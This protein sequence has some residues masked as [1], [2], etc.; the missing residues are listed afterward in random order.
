MYVPRKCNLDLLDRLSR[1]TNLKEKK[2]ILD[3]ADPHTRWLFENDFDTQNMPDYKRNH[4][5]A[6]SSIPK[7]P[8]TSVMDFLIRKNVPAKRRVPTQS[9][10][11]DPDDPDEIE[12]TATSSVPT[13]VPDKESDRDSDD[14]DDREDSDSDDP[15]DGQKSNYDDSDDREDTLNVTKTVDNFTE[16]EEDI[17]LEEEAESRTVEETQDDRENDNKD[18][19]SNTPLLADYGEGIDDRPL[20]ELLT[21]EYWFEDG[22][23][24]GSGDGA[25][26]GSGGPGDPG[27]GRDDRQYEVSSGRGEHEGGASRDRDGVQVEVGRG[28]D[29]GG[30]GRGG[31]DGRRGVGG[32]GG[33]AHPSGRPRSYDRR[34]AD[35]DQPDSEE[36][37]ENNNEVELSEDSIK[38]LADEIVK[39][40]KIHKDGTKE[41]KDDDDREHWI[42]AQEHFICR[43]CARLAQSPQVP[44][45]L[46]SCRRGNFGLV[47]RDQTK[48]KS[49]EAI[50]KHENGDLHKWCMVREKDEDKK[51][52]DLQEEDRKRG[53]KVIRNAVHCLKHGQ[54]SVDFVA[55]NNLDHINPDTEAAVKN[56]SRFAFFEIREL[57]WEI[58]TEK[59][60][61][62][63]NRQDQICHI[64][65]S[66]DKVTIFGVPYSAV[67]TYFFLRGL[68]HVIVNDLIV[69]SED[70]YCGQGTAEVLI[71]CLQRTLGISKSRLTDL[72]RH[73]AYDGV[74]ATT[75]QRTAGGGSLNLIQW[76]ARLLE[77]E[78]GSITGTWDVAHLLQVC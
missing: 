54:S 25:G 13:M 55:L 26:V 36:E 3:K 58:L 14:P 64:C 60:K 72:L 66:L 28:G 19:N 78:E 42:S 39:K 40:M 47:K 20:S 45:A 4:Q 59:T 76:V 18:E 62:L 29:R 44:K 77:V 70:D 52:S 23:C 69:M 73:L 32:G 31:Q 34:E 33:G 24:D 9:P 17:P 65:V 6:A 68:L 46:E 43:P 12:D 5:K 48:K 21:N 61:A 41:K 27:L 37:N 35:P 11:S 74:Y 49:D 50:R 15:D 22:D 8:C 2:M 1:S 57:T 38:K 67:C 7:P 10:D 71:E 56:N 75:V 30:G 53:E 63:F 51:K 16:G